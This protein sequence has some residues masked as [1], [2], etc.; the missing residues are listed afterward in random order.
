MVDASFRSSALGGDKHYVVYLP[1]GYADSGLRYPVIYMLHGL[2]GYEANWS[3]HMGLV[4][5][6]DAMKLQA[7]VV[8]PDGDDSFYANWLQPSDYQACLAGTRPFGREPDMKRY[9]VVRADYEDYVSR[10]LVAHVDATYRTLAKREARGIGG[11]SMGGYG[12]LMLAMRHLDVY[13]STASHSGVAAPLYSGPFPYRKGAATLATDID[14][15]VAGLGPIGQHLIRIFGRDVANWRDHDPTV[16][17]EKLRN[18]DLAIYLDCGTED[19][20]RLHNHAAYLH[21]V[22]EGRGI[23]H[24][25]TLLPGRHNRAF[26]SDRIDDSLRFHMSV[27]TPAVADSP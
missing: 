18:G 27:L 22:L 15:L 5:A 20:F 16:L 23:E 1:A 26:W 21:E 2:G 19:E 25:F 4:T 17:A 6:A 14:A 10:D 13:A 8:M 3:K 24:E 12:A 7:I 11:L 9:C